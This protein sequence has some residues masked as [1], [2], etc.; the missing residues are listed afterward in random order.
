MTLDWK[1]QK[2]LRQA[3]FTML[4]CGF[5][6][7]AL[8]GGAI[9]TQTL[10]GNWQRFFQSFSRIPWHEPR[11]PWI[12]GLALCFLAGALVLP[13]RLQSGTSPLS[14]LRTRTLL[15]AML[16]LGAAVCGLY[17]GMKLGSTAA[18][19]ALLLLLA[20]PATGLLLFPTEARWGR[21]LGE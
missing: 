5:V 6:A 19:L 2:A 8:Y 10:G 15:A 4:T 1:G 9:A 17:A 21:A 14:V 3:R 12:L 18:P 16:L 11:M 20:P 7:P 13:G